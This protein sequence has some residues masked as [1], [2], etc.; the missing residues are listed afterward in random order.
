MHHFSFAVPSAVALETLA[1][2]A[3]V[4]EIGAGSGYWAGLLRERAVDV[5]ALDARPPSA[6]GQPGAIDVSS[7]RFFASTFTHV[8]AGEPADLARHPDRTLFLC[9]P[10][11][12][13]EEAGRAW[14]AECLEH[15]RGNTVIYV[16]ESAG[17]TATAHAPHGVTSTAEFQRQLSESFRCS[18]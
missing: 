7:N 8:A 10:H 14:D 6:Q 13:A 5:V 12:A 4:V 1:E 18:K 16:G 17:R 9:W 11:S 3:P 2:F 15:Y